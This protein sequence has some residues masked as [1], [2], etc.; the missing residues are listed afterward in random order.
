MNTQTTPEA[1]KHTPEWF[2]CGPFDHERDIFIRMTEDGE[3]FDIANMG[4][5][6]HD[7]FEEHAKMIASAPTMK[8]QIEELTRCLTNMIAWANIKDGSP[9]QHLR[10][11]AQAVINSLSPTQDK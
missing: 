4:C 8:A 10:D 1:V 3:T 5:N 7:D 9:S 2:Q 11:E 6:E